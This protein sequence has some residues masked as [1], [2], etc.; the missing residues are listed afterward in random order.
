VVA[1]VEDAKVW[2]DLRTV[3]EGEEEDVVRAFVA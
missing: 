3:G 2:I 1:R